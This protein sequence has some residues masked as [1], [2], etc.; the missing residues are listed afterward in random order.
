MRSG[1]NRDDNR[2]RDRNRNRDKNLI[3]Q[4]NKRSAGDAIKVVAVATVMMVAI[5]VILWYIGGVVNSDEGWFARTPRETVPRQERT[6]AQ[7]D[8]SPAPPV[9]REA[10]RPA[11]PETVLTGINY[12]EHGG[13]FELPLQGA[14]GWAAT[15]LTMRSQPSGSGGAVANLSPGQGFVIVDV[16]GGW[17]YVETADGV[18]GWVDHR[19]CFINLPDIL[20]S[21]IYWN[22]NASGSIMVSLGFDIPGVTGQTMYAARA[23]NER[24]GREEYMVA[25]MYGLARSLHVAQQYA[26]ENGETLMVNEVFRPRDTQQAV[27][28]GM[29]SLISENERVRLAVTT[30]PWS[31]GFFI[32]TG[33]S[34][35]QRGAAIDASIATI[36]EY[37]YRQTGDFIYKHVLS[38]RELFMPSDM[39]ELSPRA[40]I[41]DAPQ[42]VTAAQMLAGNLR[43]AESVTPGVLRMQQAFAR[44]G[45]TPLS[46]EWWHFDHPD[47]IATANN[48][49]IRGDFSTDTVHSRPPLLEANE[50]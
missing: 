39:H 7:E 12:L 49:N 13:E 33:I 31:L 41:F 11:A 21:I 22:T 19:G 36:R 50:L 5:S 32:S 27:V 42:R 10:V 4:V 17:W 16:N 43:L 14:T 9:P 23:F 35:H 48:M 45:F 6:V 3:K 8:E 40:A 2:N 47:S 37:E 18:T 34:N 28:Q 44:G 26:L 25:G 20:P 29:N 1:N 24:L 30:A 15:G 46:S 38:Y